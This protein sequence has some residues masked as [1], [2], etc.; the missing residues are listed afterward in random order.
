MMIY[1]TNQHPYNGCGMSLM[2][3]IHSTVH[4]ISMGHSRELQQCF[5]WSYLRVIMLNYVRKSTKLSSVRYTQEPENKA[6]Y[7]VHT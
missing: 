7:S 2:E 3:D 1:T 5:K 6:T 4:R